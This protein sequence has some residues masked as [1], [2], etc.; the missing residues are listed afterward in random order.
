MNVPWKQGNINDL[1]NA[2]DA[3]FSKPD[4]KKKVLIID[5]NDIDFVHN[6]ADL[7]MIDNRIRQTLHMPPFQP[8]LPK[9][10]IKG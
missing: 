7:Q 8:S 3:F 1:N 5:T 10:E 4:Q 2:Y 6:S 9:N